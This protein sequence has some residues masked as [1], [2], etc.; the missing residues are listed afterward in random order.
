MTSEIL[1][2][3]ESELPCDISEVPEYLTDILVSELEDDEK[4]AAIERFTL[5]RERRFF[6]IEW[7]EPETTGNNSLLQAEVDYFEEII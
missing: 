2:V 3:Y 6:K 5:M 1:E 7:P 4:Y